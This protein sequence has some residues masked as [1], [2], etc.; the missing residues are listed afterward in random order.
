MNEL[1]KITYDNDRPTVSARDLHEFLE[2]NTPYTQWFDRMK[3]YGFTENVDY[4]SLSQKSEKPQGGRPQT[5]HQLTVE[6]AKELCMLQRNEKGK[7]ARQYFIELE[8]QWNT[9]ELV[10]A[11]ALK[12]ADRKIDMLTLQIAQKNQL[13]G[14]LQPKANYVDIILK[15]KRLVTI[16]Q[17][18]KDYGMSGKAMNKLLH[19]HKVQY[20]QNGQWLLYSKYHNQGYTHSKTIEITRTDGRIDVVMQSQWTQKG[21]LFIYELLKEHGILPVIEQDMQIA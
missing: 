12:L 1:I 3:E 21:R 4:L 14:E 18:A 8:K 16:T 9:P 6:M 20:S 2:V 5:N 13:I 10:F 19:E 11:R 15:N 17:I 7:Q